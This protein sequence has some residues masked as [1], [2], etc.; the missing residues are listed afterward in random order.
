MSIATRLAAF[1]RLADA[2]QSPLVARTTPG[3]SIHDHRGRSQR[4]RDPQAASVTEALRSLVA[5]RRVG[6]PPCVF[7]IETTGLGSDTVPFLVGLGGFTADG[8]AWVRQWQLD[9]PDDERA[10]WISIVAALRELDPRSLLVTYNGA[11]FDRTI[12][13]LRLRR[14]ALWDDALARRFFDDHV[15]LLPVCRRLWRASLPDCRLTTLE[16]EVLGSIRVGDPSGM[17]IAELGTR[18][19]AGDR[20]GRAVAGV[21]AVRR[22]NADDLLG[23]ASLVEAAARALAEP[24]DLPQA[25]G[26]LRHLG[27]AEH[28]AQVL[29]I[30]T[31]ALL[32]AWRD[33]AL[34]DAVRGVEL[35]LA[36]TRILRRVGEAE[37]A[38]ALLHEICTRHRGHRDA[39]TRLA[40]DCE[41]RLR[42]ADL[43]LAWL[44]TVDAPCPD[45]LARLVAK[46]RRAALVAVVPAALRS[47]RPADGHGR[48]APVPGS[49]RRA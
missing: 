8:T 13:R 9:D 26:V 5:P 27:R 19:L 20:D 42:R 33:A 44:S 10:M 35:L 30:R 25:L 46:A 15:D 34:A 41:H 31:L 28:D 47:P 45:R 22:H 16:R 49:W 37:R 39:T 12:A 4:G 24:T 6:A 2:A 23:L 1:A 14:L 11:S 32:D 17:E 38:H 18:W 40:I 21:A 48:A 29:R 3:F 43:A 36:I 7:D